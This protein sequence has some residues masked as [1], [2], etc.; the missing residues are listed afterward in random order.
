MTDRI[1]RKVSF[2]PIDRSD[3]SPVPYQALRFII[4]PPIQVH[5]PAFLDK[6]LQSEVQATGWDY[7]FGGYPFVENVNVTFTDEYATHGAAVVH[8]GAE[9]GFET[10]VTKTFTKALNPIGRTALSFDFNSD[11]PDSS[12]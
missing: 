2:E 7:Y 12:K 11:F 3:P 6:A 9:E 8:A 1:E 5:D 4:E 10:L